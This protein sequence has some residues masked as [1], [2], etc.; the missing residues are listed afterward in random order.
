MGIGVSL[1]LIAVG[2]ILIW[3]VNV[4]VSG[5]ELQTIGWILLVVGAIGGL[6][7]LIFWSSWGGFGGRRTVRDDEVVYRESTSRLARGAFLARRRSATADVSSAVEAAPLASADNAPRVSVR[8]GE[9]T[10]TTSILNLVRSDSVSAMLRFCCRRRPLVGCGP[11][12]AWN[13]DDSTSSGSSRSR[14]SS[15]KRA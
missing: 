5:V 8:G 11:W 2:A 1:L 15:P 13:S 14:R 3:A 12:K 9:V 6:L 4:T 10:R 7:S